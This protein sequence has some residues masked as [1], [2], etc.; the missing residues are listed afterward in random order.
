MNQGIGFHMRS[1][2]EN[3]QQD[4]DSSETEFGKGVKPLRKELTREI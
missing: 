2:S 4:S 3:G 1:R